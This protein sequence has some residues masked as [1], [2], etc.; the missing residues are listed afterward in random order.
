MTE[1]TRVSDFLGHNTSTMEKSGEHYT[2]NKYFIK[3]SK[4][5]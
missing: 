3:K 4:L 1:V 5:R 2:K